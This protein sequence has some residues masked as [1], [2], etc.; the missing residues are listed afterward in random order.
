[1]MT[2]TATVQTSSGSR[3]VAVSD[4]ATLTVG[5]SAREVPLALS[6]VPSL[7][8]TES[9]FSVTVG[10]APEV[11]AGTTVQVTVR[12]AAVSSEPVL[13][14]PGAPTASVLVTAPAAGGEAT[15]RATGEEADDNRL[16]LNVLPAQ[17]AVQV[18]AEGT[19]ELT[20][21][22]PGS[23]TVGD[24]F[25]VTVGVAAGTSL[26]ESVSVTATVSFRAADGEAIIEEIEVT[27]TAE[28]RTATEEFTAPVTAGVYTL[29]VSGLV[30]ETDDLRVAVTGASTSVTA[31]PV[32]VMLRLR[33]PDE[34]SVGRDYTVM[35]DTAV[36][37]PAG[38]TLVVTVRAGTDLQEVLLTNSYLPARRFSSQRRRGRGK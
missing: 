16:E 13:L 10:A 19:V 27:L 14:T 24:T 18:Q 35:V 3:Q 9:T 1:M 36:A 15:L 11:L 22:A 2:A 38:T 34:V 37:V 7:V 20:L 21:D 4:A 33:G 30:E 17:A 32:A 25:T 28:Q 23:V 5:V 26:A 12:L 8:A 31:E 29:A 6:E